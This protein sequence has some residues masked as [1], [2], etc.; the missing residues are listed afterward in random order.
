[1][2]KK[3][4]KIKTFIFQDVRKASGML[5]KNKRKNNIVDN[6]NAKA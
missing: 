3:M 2:T 6:I 1:M 4:T 5:Q